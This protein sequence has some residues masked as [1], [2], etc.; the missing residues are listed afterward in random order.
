MKFFPYFLIYYPIVEEFGT[1]GLHVA[2]LG[3]CKFRENG[4]REGRIFFS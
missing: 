1:N 2:L 3:V 4:G